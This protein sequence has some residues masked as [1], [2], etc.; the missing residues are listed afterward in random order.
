MNIHEEEKFK[1]SDEYKLT[2]STV[3]SVHRVNK[4]NRDQSSPFTFP[5]TLSLCQVAGFN[6][7]NSAM[8]AWKE[9]GI[10]WRWLKTKTTQKGRL[11][12]MSNL[13]SNQL[14]QPRKALDLVCHHG[15]CTKL[16]G[17][18]RDSTVTTGDPLSAVLQRNTHPTVPSNWWITTTEWPMRTH[19]HW[20]ILWLQL[21]TNNLAEKTIIQHRW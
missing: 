16:K 14:Q 5:C 3:F 21:T 1:S 9:K 12:K 7:F 15:L 18:D 2:L 20:T 6:N 13:N 10:Q 17:R 4:R 11:K 19:S 8:K